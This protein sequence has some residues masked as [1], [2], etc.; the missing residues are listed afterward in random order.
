MM[1]K[2]PLLSEFQQNAPSVYKVS[3]S[4]HNNVYAITVSGSRQIHRDIHYGIL[5]DT[6]AN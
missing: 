3:E 2:L 4:I 6:L 1:G 5:P